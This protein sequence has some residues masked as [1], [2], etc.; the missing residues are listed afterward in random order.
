MRFDDGLTTTAMR[1]FRVSPE[2]GIMA[3]LQFGAD[4][5]GHFAKRRVE[6]QQ[7]GMK[8]KNRLFALLFVVSL[9]VRLHSCPYDRETGLR[10]TSGYSSI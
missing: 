9:E 8:K 4:G 5:R 2:E 1:F 7:R 10:T 6:R 3:G